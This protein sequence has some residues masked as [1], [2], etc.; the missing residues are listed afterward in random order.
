MILSITSSNSTFNDNAKRFFGGRFKDVNRAGF[1]GSDQ[2]ITDRL[3]V[4]KDIRSE[5]EY[6]QSFLG[7]YNL[8]E[9]TLCRQ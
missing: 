3:F 7:Q 4:D 2:S 8:A 9:M 5:I 1:R 6:R